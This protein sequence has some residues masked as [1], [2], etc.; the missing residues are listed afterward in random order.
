MDPIRVLTFQG[1]VRE[2]GEYLEFIDDYLESYPDATLG[3]ILSN[4]VDI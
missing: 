2:F 4:E 1:S 3:D